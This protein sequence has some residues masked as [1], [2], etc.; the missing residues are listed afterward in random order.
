MKLRKVVF[1]SILMASQL[2]LSAPLKKAILVVPGSFRPP[3]SAKVVAA[4]VADRSRGPLAAGY[5]V[6]ALSQ[7]VLIP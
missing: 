6:R 7:S 4:T 5:R 3:L 1:T 2:A